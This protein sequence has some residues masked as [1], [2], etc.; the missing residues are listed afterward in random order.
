MANRGETKSQKSLSAP[1]ARYFMRKENVFTVQSKPG[2][3]TKETSVPLAF[4]LKHLLEAVGNMREAKQIIS[5][6]KVK[7]NGSVRKNHRFPV[8]LFDVVAIDDSKKKY[9]AVFDKKGR[10]VMKE[11]DAKG[12]DFKIS[13]IVN[14]R[15][16][17]GGKTWI[18]TNDGFTIAIDK[19]K[20][21]V[22]DSIKVS[23]PEA[24]IEEIY[25]MEKG[26]TVFLTGGTHVGETNKV[27]S[28]DKGS[29]QKKKFVSLGDKETGFQTVTRNVMVVGKSKPEVEVLEA[30]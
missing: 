18:T 23:L 10:I 12:K 24:K 14:K 3:H 28:V 13:K 16:V 25:P 19:E 22:D 30:E 26:Y 17:K 15:K 1:K 9:R 21:N 29:L 7:V 8:G 5:D 20:V 2:P 27:D 11:V 4:V 6:G